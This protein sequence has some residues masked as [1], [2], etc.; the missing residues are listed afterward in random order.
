MQHLIFIFMSSAWNY[1]LTLSFQHRN[2]AYFLILVKYDLI[3]SGVAL[4]RKKVSAFKTYIFPDL[5][6]GEERRS[7]SLT[8][9]LGEIIPFTQGVGGTAAAYLMKIFCMFAQDHHFH[10][11]WICLRLCSTFQSLAKIFDY[12]PSCLPCSKNLVPHLV[13]TLKRVNPQL[14]KREAI[15][16]ACRLG[17]STTWLVSDSVLQKWIA[18]S[19]EHLGNKCL[20]LVSASL[21]RP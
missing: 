7:E 6:D 17:T 8:G 18:R 3:G 12:T 21:T 14:L 16:Q 4:R 9:L 11:I 2:V 19:Y 15:G 1:L 20:I 10:L 13:L 5:S